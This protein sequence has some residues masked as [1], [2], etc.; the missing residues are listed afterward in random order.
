MFKPKVYIAGPVLLLL[1]GL[2][3]SMPAQAQQ[4]W[5]AVSTVHDDPITGMKY[6]I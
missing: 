6:A 3:L 1:L 5:Y 2:T 4:H